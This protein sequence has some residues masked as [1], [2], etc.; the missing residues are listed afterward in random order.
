MRLVRA[1][2][3]GAARPQVGAHK[4]AVRRLKP[5]ASSL[6]SLCSVLALG[7]L[8]GGGGGGGGVA[9]IPFGFAGRWGGGGGTDAP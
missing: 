2:R 6:A 1:C 5:H 7:L 8:F 9:T 3:P 4:R